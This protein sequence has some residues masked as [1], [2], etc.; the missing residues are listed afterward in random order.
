[1][2]LLSPKLAKQIAVN[3]GTPIYVYDKAALEKQADV[4]LAFPNA[5]G[6]TVRFAMKAL[7]NAAVLRIFD[8]K[9]L[10]FDA[11]SGYEAWRA[12]R[13]GI[14]PQKI[15]LSTQ[16]FPDDFADLWK[17]GIKVNAC[18]LSQID[19]IGRQFP[20]AE[21]GV[22]LNPGKGSGGTGKTNV[23]G[24]DSSFGIWHEYVDN[25]LDLA[26]QHRLKIVRVHTHIGS[27]SDPVIWQQVSQ[28]SLE[29]VKKFPDATVLNLG[30]GFKVARVSSEK[31]TDMQ[32]VGIPIKE[33]I[34]KLAKET[35]RQLHL[36]IEP[37]TFL[38]A[39]CGVVISRIQDIVDTG[40][41]GHRFLKLDTGMTD[42]L[43]PSLYGA[44]HPVFTVPARDTGK[45]HDYVVVGHCCESG[46]LVTCAPGDPEALS[47]RSLPEVQIDDIC[48]I[49]GAGAY[50]SA[51]SSKNYNSFPESAEVLID[52]NGKP[53]LIRRR[54]ML[55]Q[56]IQNEI[57]PEGL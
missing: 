52:A 9:G 16:E 10:H 22:R 29:L 57:L 39:N 13:A 30:G 48:V 41:A 35:D 25:V 36:E 56:I 40:T 37:G 53:T 45:K 27:G 26:R 42:I 32:T 17:T 55:E 38:V 21:I 50:C 46:D 47:S 15:S 18:S 5:F 34:E 49:G 43:R 24:P 3:F 7:P 11:S 20:G 6:L 4:A 1:M 33:A 23:G 44:Q 31:G 54:Q 8:R 2:S 19:R 28:M 51:M 12:I 14:A